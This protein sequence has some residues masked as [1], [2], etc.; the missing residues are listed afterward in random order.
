M[1]KEVRADWNC[2]DKQ[3]IVTQY[4]Y[5]IY[6]IIIYLQSS[7]ALV[8]SHAQYAN[9]AF[10]MSSLYDFSIISQKDDKA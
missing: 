7:H 4:I 9:D 1:K 3:T 5:R 8:P 2:T 10:F 6:D